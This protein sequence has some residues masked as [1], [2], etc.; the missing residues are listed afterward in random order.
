MAE[1]DNIL[2]DSVSLIKSLWLHRKGNEIHA[3]VQDTIEAI[4]RQDLKPF[5]F[6]KHVAG[7]NHTFIIHLPPGL[8]YAD[9]KSKEVFFRDSTGGAVQVE[10]RGKAVIMT[11]MT[12]ELKSCYPYAWNWTPYENMYLPAP[13]GY[14]ANGLLVRDLTRAPNL[15][16]AGH[17]GAGKTNEINILATSLL[18][19]RDNFRL[20]IIDQKEVDYGYLAD[21]GL[22]IVVT[23]IPTIQKV[24]RF[25]NT[26][27]DRRKKILR[28]AK[29]RRL[30]DY[31]GPEE[32]PWI[33]LIVDELAELHDE[34][35]QMLLN[36]ILRLGRA[37]G[38]VCICAT[39]R[40]SSTLFQK[41][42]FG[43]SK[44]M[45]SASICF[46]VRDAINS[47]MV[48]DND[49]AALLPGDV[50]GR[51]I[52][53]WDIEIEFQAMEWTEKKVIKLLNEV[54]KRGMSD[55]FCDIEPP[56]RLPPRQKYSIRNR[57]NGCP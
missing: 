12:D 45:F 15:F 36:R 1:Q 30:Q 21:L 40:P 54:A 18:L 39:Q 23:D 46:H 50:P 11:V 53:Q 38:F 28:A 14:S 48:L 49:R 27:L 55:G 37:E 52:F 4:W 31:A 8:C 2:K 22:G 51:G 7:N 9:F 19:A 35:C 3:S 57:T 20:I 6:K 34:E 24:L 26:E 41:F 13:V 33:V 43:D 16:I 42:S 5:I 32:L 47:R 29:V 56:K 10:K 25:L 17:P 44:A